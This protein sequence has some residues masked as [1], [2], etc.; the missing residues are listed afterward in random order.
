M[1]RASLSREEII[2]KYLHLVKYVAGRISAALPSN[3]EIGDLINDGVFG[4]IDAIEKYDD[5]RAVKFETYAIMRINGSILDALRSLDWVPR[6]I[7]QRAREV[8]RAQDA[9]ESELG[10]VPTDEEL[11]GRLRL[12][13]RELDRLRQ[14]MRGASLSSLEDSVAGETLEDEQSDVTAQLER[15]EARA[16]LVAAME[17]L[18]P[19]ERTVIRRYYFNGDTLKAIKGEL[20]VSES[21]VSQIH[22][23]AVFHL[24]QR[25]RASAE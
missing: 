6:S 8:E 12:P 2:H 7:R 23:K 10:R 15:D 24:R 13:V 25:L 5:D 3:V 16:E 21:R 20:D 14:R 22:A 11:A 9:L 4:L 17:S 19:Q 18:P 1:A